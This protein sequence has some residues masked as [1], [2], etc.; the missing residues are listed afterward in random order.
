M[1]K[2]IFTSL[3]IAVAVFFII[4]NISSAAT[5]EELQA[6]VASLLSQIKQLQAEIAQKQ[7]TATVQPQQWCHTFSKD[8]RAG[9]AGTE[10]PA[11]T[12]ALAKEGVSSVSAFQEKYKSEILTPV[13][14]KTATGY[15]GN[16]TRAKLN[17]LY[18]C[19]TN[20]V[21]PTITAC[22]EEAK[23]CPDGSYV[24]RD[25]KNSCEFKACPTTL[26]SSITV[27]SP[28]GGEIWTKGTT[29]TI[30]WQDSTKVTGGCGSPTD[31]TLNC[32][33]P[34]PLLYDIW[35]VS[36]GCPQGTACMFAPQT[37]AKSVSGHTY[38]WS[39]NVVGTY[40]I[41]I[42]KTGTG[43]F[44]S[45]DTSDA[46]FSVISDQTG[47]PVIS[48][49]SGPTVLSIGQT[50]T[51]TVKASDPNNSTLNYSVVW[52]DEKV[53]TYNTQSGGTSSQVV[54]QSA[55]FTH[56]YGTIGNYAPVFIVTNTSG[57]TAQTSLSVWVNSPVIQPTNTN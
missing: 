43:S 24:G 48:G 29:Q 33:S 14:L 35:L 32:V 47:V 25:S 11:L 12:S 13:G 46:A 50:G 20:I 10:S 19:G 41:Q 31:T 28:N 55:T 3:F 22:T 1:Y 42:C 16:R 54:S 39:T 21:P 38:V 27:L 26:Q 34:A 56:V 44:S 8:I 4:P 45:C 9:S 53:F 36:A 15:V 18:G 49:V 40:K 7:T 51:W 6:Q 52:G 23:L 17:A 5:I 30:K 37:I 57:K 2:K